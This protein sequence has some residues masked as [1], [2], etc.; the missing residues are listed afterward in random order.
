MDQTCSRFSLTSL[1]RFWSS[2]SVL[3]PVLFAVYMYP[4]RQIISLKVH[5]I[6]MQMIQLF[7]ISEQSDVFQTNSAQ[8]LT[9]IHEFPAAKTQQVQMLAPDSQSPNLKSCIEFVSS[10]IQFKNWRCCFWPPGLDFW[11][12]CQMH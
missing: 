10:S 9:S 1:M 6:S 3:G 12:A 7:I 11:P 5:I 8:A 2:S 4:L